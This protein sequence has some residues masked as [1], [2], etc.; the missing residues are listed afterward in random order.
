MK[1]CRDADARGVQLRGAVAVKVRDPDVADTVDRDREWPCEAAAHEAAAAVK[2]A[3][4][5]NSTP[6]RYCR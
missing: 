6:S 5:P 3:C 2:S 1:A 4:P